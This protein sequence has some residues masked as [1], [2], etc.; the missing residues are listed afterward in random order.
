MSYREPHTRSQAHRGNQ[1]TR[2]TVTGKP[3]PLKKHTSGNNPAVLHSLR[4]HLD[5]TIV[6]D[7][8]FAVMNLKRQLDSEA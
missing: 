8:V 7:Q 4:C 1:I 6:Q 5:M 2:Q 3:Q